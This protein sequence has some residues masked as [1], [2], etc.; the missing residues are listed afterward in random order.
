MS[1]RLANLQQQVQK[2]LEGLEREAKGMR[3]QLAAKDEEIETLRKALRA[4]GGRQEEPTHE[5][6][7]PSGSR[8]PATTRLLR[9]RALLREAIVRHLIEQPGLTAGQLAT[10]IEGEWG[11]GPLNPIR[12]GRMI[13]FM[14]EVVG[15]YEGGYVYVPEAG[16]VDTGNAKQPPE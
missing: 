4:L 1:L 3:D 15:D 9:E 16:D 6:R 5:R 14:S 2:E 13:N 12:I 7:K 11:E 8:E 10:L